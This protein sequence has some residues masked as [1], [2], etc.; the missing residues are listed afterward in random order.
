MIEVQLRRG[1][2]LEPAELEG[3]LQRFVARCGG[4]PH[5]AEVVVSP[6][7]EA[8]LL[9]CYG[10]RPNLLRLG[11]ALARRDRAAIRLIRHEVGAQVQL[12]RAGRFY[13]DRFKTWQRT[14][15]DEVAA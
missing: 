8:A 14:F 6:T 10:C 2:K 9:S 5:L 12:E 11:F 7:G 3:Q 15:T 4:R 13:V 1:A